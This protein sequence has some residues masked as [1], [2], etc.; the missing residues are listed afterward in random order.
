MLLRKLRHRLKLKHSLLGDSIFFAFSLY[1][2]TAYG[3]F[4]LR[5]LYFILSH[6]HIYIYTYVQN[7]SVKIGMTKI[8]NLISIFL[9][10]QYNKYLS[11]RGLYLITNIKTSDDTNSFW[12]KANVLTP[13]QYAWVKPIQ[14]I[15]FKIKKY[16]H[17]NF[18]TM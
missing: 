5:N 4:T 3:R 2:T 12:E 8:W 15:F 18:H 7:M 10:V 17:G 13:T 14:C 11:F 9:T 1:G 16:L 6:M